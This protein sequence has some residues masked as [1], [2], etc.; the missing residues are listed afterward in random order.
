VAFRPSLPNDSSLSKK[1]KKFYNVQSDHVFVLY[2]NLLIFSEI[3]IRIAQNIIQKTLI[4][5]YC[6]TLNITTKR[7][8]STSPSS[9]R[10]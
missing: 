1:V 7:F 4:L 10:F 9:E 3:Q 5:Q 6:P 8:K 2:V